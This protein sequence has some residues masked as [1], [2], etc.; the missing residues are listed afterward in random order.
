MSCREIRHRGWQ[1]KFIFFKEKKK[2]KDNSQQS[3][4]KDKFKVTSVLL[5]L[6]PQHTGD[7]RKASISFRPF[8]FFTKHAQ[9]SLD[10]RLDQALGNLIEPWCLCSLQGS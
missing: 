7:T 10:V 2:N 5:G 1:D 3:D 6:V 8:M 9:K 4:Q